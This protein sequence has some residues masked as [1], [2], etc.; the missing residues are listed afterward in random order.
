MLRDMKE[1]QHLP[2]GDREVRG[3]MVR[4]GRME[5]ISKLSSP[6]VSREN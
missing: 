6:K 3:I 4:A 5:I 1:C 2:A